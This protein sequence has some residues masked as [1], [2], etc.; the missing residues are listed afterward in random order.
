MGIHRPWEDMKRCVLN[1]DGTVNYYLDATDSTKKANGTAAVITGADG[2]VMVEIPAFYYKYVRTGDVNT[3]NIRTTPYT[4]YTLHPAFVK[5]GVEVP[6][7][8]IG[9]YQACYLDATDATYKSGLN[10]DDM[11]A[12]LDLVNDKLASVSGVY[13]LVGVTRAETRSLGR[14][15]GAGWHQLDFAL[16]SAVQM[17]FLA[18]YN[19]FNSQLKL[20]V[21]NTNGSYLT[22]SA[23]QADSP[24][25]I[26]GASNAWGNG[27]TNGTQPSAG[28]KPGTAYMSYRGIENWFG[29]AWQWCDGINVN[30][31]TAGLVHYTNNYLNFADNTATNYTQITSAFPTASGYIKNIL[32]GVGFGFLSSNNTGG[33]SST[34]LTD[35]HY[36][37]ASLS[38]VVWVGG[39]AASGADAGGFCLASVYDSGLVSRVVGARLCF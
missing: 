9:A 27:S 38:R 20:G 34:F 6:Y 26:A 30:I 29:N 22:S 5:A 3:W 8:Y 36:A 12:N 18:E 24:H 33:S 21:G 11:T 16:W 1:S 14:N 25:T 15:A 28:A 13:P 31:G 7:R 39:Y 35:Y 17:L 23:I 10:L 32:S 2:N 19:S 37:S 4:G